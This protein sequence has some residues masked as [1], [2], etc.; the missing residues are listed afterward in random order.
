MTNEL[1][2]EN[3]KLKRRIDFLETKNESYKNI[4]KS[5]KSYLFKNLITLDDEE[6]IFNGDIFILINILEKK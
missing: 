3:I 2:K 5:A 1:E 6:W 4:I